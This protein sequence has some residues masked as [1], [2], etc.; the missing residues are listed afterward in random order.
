MITWI[1]TWG[2]LDIHSYTRV[3]CR[4]VSR[5]SVCAHAHLLLKCLIFYSIILSAAQNVISSCRII[6]KQC[7]ETGVKV[8]DHGLVWRE[9]LECLR[10]AAIGVTSAEP[11]L[12]IWISELLHMTQEGYIRHQDVWCFNIYS[13]VVVTVVAQRPNSRRP[14]PFSGF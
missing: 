6:S 10:T 7:V 5:V 13:K 9:T 1:I 2:H 14:L 4:R 8:T 3:V 11:L 12:E